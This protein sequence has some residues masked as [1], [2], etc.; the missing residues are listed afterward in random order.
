[1]H[2]CA[3]LFRRKC[4]INVQFLLETFWYVGRCAFCFL[5][6]SSRRSISKSLKKSEIITKCCLCLMQ[7]QFCFSS[8]PVSSTCRH[9]ALPDNLAWRQRDQLSVFLIF[10]AFLL[11]H[12]ASETRFGVADGI[13]VRIHVVF[14]SGPLELVLPNCCGSPSTSQ[15]AVSTLSVWARCVPFT[16]LYCSELCNSGLCSTRHVQVREMTYCSLGNLFQRHLSGLF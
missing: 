10:Q 16:K 9:W 7:T 5:A 15:Y 14:I 8:S 12:P 6:W 4:F 13:S 1:M 2:F 3:L 11:P